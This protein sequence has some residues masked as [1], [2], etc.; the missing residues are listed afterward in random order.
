MQNYLCDS[1]RNPIHSLQLHVECIIFVWS[2]R[3]RKTGL[4]G[5]TFAGP[6]SK[7]NTFEHGVGA[8]MDASQLWDGWRE[9]FGSIYGFKFYGKLFETFHSEIT[10]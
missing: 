5:F 6:C 9:I 3:K 7:F 2:R 10:I 1:Y 4:I 8:H